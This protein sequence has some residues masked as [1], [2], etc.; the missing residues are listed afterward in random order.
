MRVRAAHAGAPGRPVPQ[1]AGDPYAV[2]HLG[3]GRRGGVHE[4]PVEHVPARGVQR[5]DPGV[6]PDRD[7]DRLVAGEEEHGAAHRRGARR[8]DLVEQTPPGQLQ[9][10]GPHQAVGGQRVAAV[11]RPRRATSTRAPARAS[12]IAVEAP[13]TRPPTTTTSYAGHAHRSSRAL[14]RPGESSRQGGTPRR[15]RRAGRRRSSPS[16]GGAG[17]A[18]RRRRARRR[19][20]AAHLAEGPVRCGDGDL[21]PRVVRAVAGGEQHRPDALGAEVEATPGRPTAPAPAGRRGR[22]RR[23]GGCC[24]TCASTMSRNR[25][26]RASAW[27]TVA[28]RSSA[29]L[30]RCPWLQ[31][32]PPGQPRRPRPAGCQVDVGAAPSRGS[33][34][35]SWN[36]GS[37]RAAAGSGTVS[38]VRA[39]RPVWSSHQCTSRPR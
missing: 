10:P 15:G 1:Q 17:S 22:P 18:G 7:A 2:A 32:Q 3:T 25:A 14:E 30:T 9:H 31:P 35:A 16:R 27:P 24:S 21:Q 36:D 28:P 26:S 12:S 6:R 37:R 33:R 11:R 5:L 13:A 29:N 19:G 8:D 23:R 20:G 34:P 4:D 38:M 39:R